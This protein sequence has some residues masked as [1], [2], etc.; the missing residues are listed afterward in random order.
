MVSSRNIYSGI[1]FLL[2]LFTW[3]A[4]KNTTQVNSTPPKLPVIVIEPKDVPLYA[5]YVG[6]V[7]GEKDI[8]VRARVE[9]FL[10]KINFEEGQFVKQNDLLY[11]VDA[12]PYEAKVNTQKSKLAEAETRLT[13]SKNDLERY[14]P[15]AEADAVSQSDLDAVQAEY[16][17]AISSVAAAKANLRSAEIELGYTRVMSPIDGIIGKTNAKVG[18]FVGREPNPVILNTVSQTGNMKVQFF[19]T[20]AQYIQ[21]ARY[22]SERN[23]S[24]KNNEDL[25]KASEGQIELILADGT[26]YE[27]KGTIEFIDRGINSSTGTIL[28]QADFPNPKLVLRPG[29][30]GKIKLMAREIKGGILVPQRCVKELQGMNSLYL[31]GDSNKIVNQ[32]I[33]V[34]TTVNDYY[35]IKSGLKAGDKVLLEGL[36][37]VRPGMVIDPQMTTFSSQQPN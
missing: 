33:E 20:E 14:K 8:D 21:L 12:Q 23:D 22:A 3:T 37:K 35:L 32:Q 18:D 4:C 24:I 15:L 11:V 26:T 17:A 34:A 29:M 31:V 13:K 9:G 36:Q 27:E 25:R 10:Q 16:D 1:L 28:V 19:L 7:Y 5:E 6:Q 30:Y 2:S